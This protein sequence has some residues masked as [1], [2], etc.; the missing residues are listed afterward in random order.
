MITFS[1][2]RPFPKTRA[3]ITAKEFLKEHRNEVIRIE[4]TVTEEL[5]TAYFRMND[6]NIIIAR[7]P[8]PQEVWSYI[9][10]SQYLARCP[11]NWAGI[12]SIVKWQ[13]P[14][15]SLT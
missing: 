6:D 13:A 4:V 8:D 15:N 1:N 11:I 10:Q 12:E 7:S 2:M 14:F 9:F 5:T 3:P